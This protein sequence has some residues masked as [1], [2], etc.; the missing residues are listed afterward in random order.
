MKHSA[1]LIVFMFSLTAL[2]NPTWG[3]N[4]PEKPSAAKKHS[5]AKKQKAV[6]KP[7]TARKSPGTKVQKTGAQTGSKTPSATTAQAIPE[8]AAEPVVTA[9]IIVAPPKQAVVYTPLPQPTGNPYLQHV[10][11]QPVIL[12]PP[13]VVVPISKPNPFEN[14]K[15]TLFSNL[16]DGL[17]QMHPPIYWD[18]IKGPGKPLLL[19][20]VSCPTKALLGFDTPVIAALQLGVDQLLELANKTD[21]LPAEIQRVCR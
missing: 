13:M 15:P 17:G 4:L 18:L 3:G 10:L 6:K 20:Q 9:A 5:T 7:K 16:T 21:L 14:L 12:P 1:L 2:I 11:V 19:V 8:I